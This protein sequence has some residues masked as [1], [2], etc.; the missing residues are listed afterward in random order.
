MHDDGRE[1]ALHFQPYVR[2]LR[3]MHRTQGALDPFQYPA[4]VERPDKSGIGAPFA[5]GVAPRFVEGGNVVR[6]QCLE[7]LIF[8]ADRLPDQTRQRLGKLPQIAAVQHQL[9]QHPV[10][11]E[12]AFDHY[13]VFLRDPFI[14]RAGNID[15]PCLIR[16]FNQGEI[17]DFRRFT[18]MR[19]RMINVASNRQRQRRH[20]FL[21]HCINVI[22]LFDGIGWHVDRR[23]QHQFAAVQPQWGIGH[24]CNVNPPH[25]AVE[26]RVSGDHP[27]S[28]EFFQLQCI[29]NRQHIT[30]NP[31]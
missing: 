28:G 18:Q 29:G 16:N 19:W 21:R 24:T 11:V 13:H 8:D 12:G 22:A 7:T 9:G 20:P 25:R 1:N 4:L 5:E 31:T 10:N 6:C 23:G 3:N 27:R 26:S 15:K 17:G 30:Q 14:G 2:H